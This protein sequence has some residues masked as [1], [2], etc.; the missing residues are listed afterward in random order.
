MRFRLVWYTGRNIAG[1]SEPVGTYLARYDYTALP[2]KTAELIAIVTT[3][4]ALKRKISLFL[5][6]LG[7][8]FLHVYT[9]IYIPHYFP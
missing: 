3:T 7:C 9:H 4:S 1:S 5:L 8:H 6:E 2:P